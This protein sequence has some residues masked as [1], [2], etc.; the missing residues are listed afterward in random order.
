LLLLGRFAE[1]WAE[2]EWR[3][4]SKDF[5]GTISSRSLS[6]ETLWDGSPLRGRT[7]LLH[8][9]QGLGDTLQFV[10]YAALLKE[11]GAGKVVVGCPPEL[12]RLLQ[13]CAGV[14]QAVTEIAVTAFDVHTFPL[15]LP[16]LLETTSVERIPA[17]VPYLDIDTRL[18]ETWK[19]R[20]AALEEQ[21]PRLRVGI[22]WQG[23]P[24]H[25]G[26]R[27]RS[28]RLQQFAPLAELPGVRLISLQKGVGR[29]QLEKL[30]GLAL[31]LGPELT[32]LADTAAVIRN[33]DL[34]ISVDTVVAHLAGALA[35]PVWVV[36]PKVPDWRWLL[37]REDSPWYPTMRLFRQAEHGQWDDVFQRIHHALAALGSGFRSHLAPRDDSSHGA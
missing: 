4:K 23:N 29:E 32:D 35:A 20:L 30:P 6:P 27:K 9:E 16:R 25:K 26:D 1:G 15:N 7:I 3:W 34:V 37:Q 31:D 22:V 21:D 24:G 13:R 5:V 12:L 14:D 10:R 17:N 33:L 18:V 11:K 28:V 36:L 19:A 8:Q 2:Y